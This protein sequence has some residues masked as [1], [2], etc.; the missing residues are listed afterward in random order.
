[1][2]SLE[3]PESVIENKDVFNEMLPSLRAD[4]LLGKNYKYYEDEPLACPLTAVAGI[5]D[6]VFTEDQIMEWKRHTSAEFSF[7]KVNGSH[8]FCRDNKEELLEILTGEL[9]DG[10]I[11]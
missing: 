5:N 7:K 4:I 11:A 10:V 6:T 8:L 9:S 2:R 1:L 3:I